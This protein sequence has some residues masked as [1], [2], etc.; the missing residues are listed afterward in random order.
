VCAQGAT[1]IPVG[2][3]LISR[4][5]LGHLGRGLGDAFGSREGEAGASDRGNG[6]KANRMTASN[7]HLYLH[8]PLWD[9]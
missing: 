4:G 5:L 1:L 9:D 6:T 3:G 8:G 7:D 2:L